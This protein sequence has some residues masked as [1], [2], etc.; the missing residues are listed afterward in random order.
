MKSEDFKKGLSAVG[1]AKQTQPLGLIQNFSSLIN[2]SMQKSYF[3]KIWSWIVIAFTVMS[4]SVSYAQCPSTP[5]VSLTFKVPCSGVGTVGEISATVTGGVGPYTFKLKKGSSTNIISTVTNV[6]STS[7]T[8]SNLVT[9][10][11]SYGYSVVVVDQ[12]CSP[13][14]TSNEPLTGTVMQFVAVNAL[15]Y[16]T[17][18]NAPSVTQP[19]LCNGGNGV[20]SAYIKGGTS[21]RRVKWTN[22]ANPSLVY[23]SSPTSTVIT[24]GFIQHTTSVPPGTYSGVIEDAYSYCTTPI[25]T[26]VVVNQ[27]QY[28]PLSVSLSPEKACYNSSD[29]TLNFSGTGGYFPNGYNF[30]LYQGS[31]TSGLLLQTTGF[32]SNSQNFS[33]LAPG[34]YS[35]KITDG[36]ACTSTSNATIG[37]LPQLNGSITADFATLCA[38]QPLTFTLSNTNTPTQ[39]PSEQINIG[40]KVNDSQTI[41]YA[42]FDWGTTSQIIVPNPTTNTTDRWVEL[43]T[44]SYGN[45]TAYITDSVFT[46]ILPLPI[47]DAGLPQVVCEGSDITLSGSSQAIND[48]LSWYEVTY[49]TFDPISNLTFEATLDDGSAWM[50]RNFALTALGVNGCSA[51]DEIVVTINPV[52][53][54]NNLHD[55][56]F[57][58]GDLFDDG[59]Q[60]DFYFDNSNLI[61]GSPGVNY[62]WTNDNT[63]IGMAASSMPPNNYVFT[64]K[65][66][67]GE[68]TAANPTDA[69]ISGTV[70]V[71]PTY[72]YIGLTCYGLPETFTITVNPTPALTSALSPPAICTGATFEYTAVSPT[73]PT[74]GTTDISWSRSTI[75]GITEQGTTGQGDISEV[76][77]NTTDL[78][79]DVTYNYT[80]VSNGCTEYF[81][82]VVT[83]NPDPVVDDQTATICSDVAINVTL[84]NDANTPS[85]ATYNITNIDAN[86]MTAS[87]GNPGIGNGKLSSEIANDAWTNTTSGPLDVVYTIIPVATSTG[88]EGEPFTVTVT[89]NPEPVGIS[90]NITTCSD[91]ALAETL[92]DL[93]VSNSL[94]GVT[95]TW[96]ANANASVG[97]EGSG[98]GNLTNTLNNV[99]AVAVNVT[100]VIT[101]S[102]ALGCIGN[103][104][105]YIVSVNPEPV[106]AN[107]TATVCS[108]AAV[109]LTLATD[110]NTP[111]VASYN[112]TSIDN[113]NLLAS[114]GSPATGNALPNSE[115]SD[116]KWTNTTGANVH[117]IYTIVPVAT[118]TSCLGDPFT[119]NI[120]V[121]PEPIVS[122]DL[123]ENAV[124]SDAFVNITV[125]SADDNTDAIDHYTVSVNANGLTP[126][127]FNASLSGN[128]TDFSLIHN[129]SYTNITGAQVSVVYTITPYFSNNCP[130]DAFTITIPINPEPIISTSLTATA[131]C[132]DNQINVTIPSTDD[133]GSSIDHFS[134]SFYPNQTILLSG[135]VSSGSNLTDFG[136][137]STNIHN[138]TNPLPKSPV[139]TITPYFS[140]G[141][142][143]SNFT[144][145]VPINPE[146]VVSDQTATV[147]SDGVTGVTLGTD[148]NTP[149]VASYNITNINSN[150]LIAS[151]GSPTTGT[152]LA[153][154]EISDDAWTNTTAATVDVIY[155][156]VPVATTTGCEGNPFTVTV[157]INPEPVVA[158]QTLT[159]CSDVATGLSLGTDINT[160]TVA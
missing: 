41:Q 4:L 88:C 17:T 81:D 68:F 100:Y 130:G 87:A 154:S 99:T 145:T 111:T 107:Q 139:Y 74:T 67:Y 62:T 137:I 131:V 86:G 159:I 144:I 1:F 7:Y 122:Q 27:S 32:A 114:G 57:C 28:N 9:Q 112:I 129:D 127:Q 110:A 118:S 120:T 123:T 5:V 104:F 125:P 10:T 78:P 75:A 44:A 63:A 25:T 105:N 84:G 126:G 34:D 143:G 37:I 39:N 116:D 93:D 18:T 128:Q 140:T 2:R 97:G 11:G 149:T 24:G 51:T 23:Y 66:A 58:E 71:V 119:V 21:F 20:I 146:P 91:V 22:T 64:E 49:G 15:S 29:G 16:N 83:V 138:N 115:I 94:S 31:N 92:N 77:T 135:G 40:Y 148:A 106:V 142:V 90:G 38:G 73:V 150:G 12:G 136:V 8:W 72:T 76:L 153:S 54:V 79:I 141:C 160:P 60:S 42:Q 103:N 109:G 65:I 53:D 117:V 52:P 46:D 80:V 152:G 13:N 108:D 95:Y 45:C 96:A 26:N 36:N 101:P 3:T 132:S 82:V 113:N 6:A 155:T 147:C 158:D 14:T 157:T 70:T 19:V 61:Y 56:V 47:V 59:G 50:E 33:G 156:V 124:C 69:A 133:N 43:V 48:V 121:Q 35:V 134:L 102:S 30:Q 151:A 89:I 98:S 85:V 55:F